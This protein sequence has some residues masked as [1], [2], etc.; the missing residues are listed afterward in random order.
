MI[1]GCPARKGG[2]MKLYCASFPRLLQPCSPPDAFERTADL[3]L[4]LRER[5][6]DELPSALE[7]RLLKEQFFAEVAVL[8]PGEDLLQLS[9]EALAAGL[10]CGALDGAALYIADTFPEPFS[11][12]ESTV[13][14]L[15]Q[16]VEVADQYWRG[17]DI[18]SL[19]EQS[20]YGKH[21]NWRTDVE[22]VGSGGDTR[23]LLI[24]TF[25]TG[26]GIGMIDAALA[27]LTQDIPEWSAPPADFKP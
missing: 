8:K 17:L 5:G 15:S 2:A 26:Y 16:T 9:R 7:S 6:P 25:R 22:N 19:G 11:A 10:L 4:T 13:A 12:P 24:E 23:T 27:C 18:D 21:L 3:L 14:E 20:I 1:K